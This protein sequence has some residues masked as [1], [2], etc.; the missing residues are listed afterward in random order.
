MNPNIN[1]SMYRPFTDMSIN[2]P[3]VTSL[4]PQYSSPYSNNQLSVMQYEVDNLSKVLKSNGQFIS[5]P[6]C[7]SQQVTR[8]EQKLSLVNTLCGILTGPIPWLIFQSLRKKDINCYDAE[9]YCVQCGM[10]IANYKAC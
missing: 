6:Y 2:P 5:C 10:K 7:K 9:H 1:N 8:T 3:T 4:P